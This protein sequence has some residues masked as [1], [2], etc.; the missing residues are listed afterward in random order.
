MTVQNFFVNII[1][2][3]CFS[4]CPVFCLEVLTLNFCLF[5]TLPDFWVSLNGLENVP[6][7]PREWKIH[8]SKIGEKL[9]IPNKW[10]HIVLSPKKSPTS[11]SET[12]K[13]INHRR[14]SYKSK[15]L[16]ICSTFYR[17]FLTFLGR[18]FRFRKSFWCTCESIYP[19]SSNIVV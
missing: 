3:L 6:R 12:S 11:W 19:R 9:F 2:V 18:W 1:F 13:F 14:W 7:R 4:F 10:S 8:G 5:Q 15:F 17:L 16:Q